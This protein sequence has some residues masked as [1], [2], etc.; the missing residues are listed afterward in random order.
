[1]SGGYNFSRMTPASR[2]TAGV[3]SACPTRCAAAQALVAL[4]WSCGSCVD[5]VGVTSD[6][7][8]SD[9]GN[10]NVSPSAPL[11]ALPS[12]M[13]M[14]A[15][16][17]ASATPGVA[18]NTRPATDAGVESSRPAPE[19]TAA[20]EAGAPVGPY[21]CAPSVPRQAAAF[22][23]PG[24]LHKRSDVE[25]MRYMF[26][27]E[28]EPWASS[29]QALLAHTHASEDY[30]VRGDASWTS[31]DREGDH[32]PEWESDATAAY[33]NAL[34]W[35]L[36]GDV[37]HA[38]KCVEIFN[39]WVNLTDVSGGGTEALNAGLF[40]WKMVEAAELVRWTYDGWNSAD[41]Q[42]FS[43][44]L[45]Y[46]GYSRTEVP[47]DDQGTFYWRIY[48]GD[49][50]RHGNQDL[51]AWRAMVTMG[52]FLD[53][54]TMFDRALNYVKGLPHP[55]NDLPY[56][57]GPSPSGTQL[58][59][60]E[61]TTTYQYVGSAETDADFGYNG[62][63]EHYIWENGQC[64][65]SSRDQQH[66]FFGLGAMAGIAEVAWNQ[67]DELYNVLENRLLLGF[68]FT[69]RYNTSW[70][71]SFPDQPDPWEPAVPDFIQ[72]LD[73]TGRWLSKAINPYFESDFTTLSRGDFPGKRPVFEQ[74]LAH[75]QVR[76]GLPPE[77][78]TWTQ[79]SR[80][81]AIELSG[82][83]GVGFS[84]DHPG[85]GALTFRRPELGAGDPISGFDTRGVP[86][87]EIPVLPTSIEAE[88]Y[89]YFPGN[90]Q[91]HTYWDST[92]SNSA[93]NYRDDGV[94]VGCIADDAYGLTETE[95]G[96]WLSYTV[97]VPETRNYRVTARYRSNV[98]DAT[99]RIGFGPSTTTPEAL[100]P[101]SA[102]LDVST[103]AEELELAAGVV[104]MRVFVVQGG[105]DLD[106]IVIE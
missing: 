8:P 62:V 37:G 83:E 42:A 73:R 18:A 63:L 81:A 100:L 55:Q 61:Y 13:N 36:T 57:T 77:S 20:T 23:H 16:L 98:A 94:D 70:V 67:G 102:H 92:D 89:D 51:I 40:A 87:F 22:V 9:G 75:Y 10:P 69:G 60:N 99:I 66:A 90:G 46:P 97:F 28:V 53:N 79:R 45:V 56:A 76:M 104:V 47:A 59:D 78:T 4:A 44:M 1:M 49:P 72:R 105:F 29:G 96:E 84:L 34:A 54:S 106:S 38:E 26:L 39:T 33:L 103:V 74:P 19:T 85:W 93:S 2:S 50:G 41:V 68:E 52:V 24:G 80:D 14:P 95:T 27:A 6:S 31:V 5:G 101:R 65:E 71:T 86:T 48:R 25:R 30:E 82:N 43:E 21:S 58:D 12:Q 32:G 88:H 7:S 35:T 3:R 17:D 91:D 64:Q 15:S 11:P